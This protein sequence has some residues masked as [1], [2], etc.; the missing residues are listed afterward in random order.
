MIAVDATLALV[1]REWI[2]LMR[3]PARIVATVGTPLVLLVALGS[4]FAGS[5]SGLMGVEDSRA[6]GA[7]LLPGMMSMA[8][9]FASIFGA[10]SLIEDRE[11]GLLLVLLAGPAPS[12]S[13]VLAK[14]VGVGLPAFAQAM[15]LL[16]AAWILGIAPSLTQTLLAVLA[17]LLLTLGIVSVSLA[18]A[19]RVRSSQEFHAVMNTL[20]MPMWLLSGSFY[21]AAQAAPPMRWL[22]SIN[23]LT[24]PVETLR[25]ALAGEPSPL[26]GQLAWPLAGV[27]AVGLFLLAMGTI[28]LGRRREH[29]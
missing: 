22:T 12:G 14:V 18:L 17:T 10:I 3:Q 8:A 13:I 25:S 29:S 2:R 4:G 6:Y 24:W 26:L 5:I 1:G 27:F 16:P 11:G 15:L 7:F 9:L 20:L 28:G 21:P 19:W 23:P